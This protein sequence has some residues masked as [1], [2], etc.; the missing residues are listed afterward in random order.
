MT[1]A[2]RMLPE[3]DQEIKLT[4]SMLERVPVEH[5]EWRPHAKSTPL[6]RLAVHVATIPRL[7]VS[8]LTQDELEI[9]PAAGGFTP[10]VLTSREGLLS[11]F[12]DF[13]RAAREAIAGTADEALQQPWTLKHT[14]AT[15][16]T[17]PRIAVVRTMFLN[18]IIHHRGQLSV[19]LRLL[20][21]P[22]PRIYGP[23]ADEPF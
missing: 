4:R 1:I 2:Q 7:A 13:A 22:V 20:D 19:Y 9:N 12:D 3:V 16:F 17:L 10:P 6:G 11:T 8:A 5:A 21:V 15:V 23:S 14:G 18:H